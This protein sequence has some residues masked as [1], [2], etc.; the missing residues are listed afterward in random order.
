MTNNNLTVVDTESQA[1]L[2]PPR[3]LDFQQYEHYTNGWFIGFAKIDEEGYGLD[4]G[5]IVQRTNKV[6]Y[7]GSTTVLMGP[8]TNMSQSCIDGGLFNSI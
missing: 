3:P 5:F 8:D 4:G 1:K 6:G 7:M 2:T